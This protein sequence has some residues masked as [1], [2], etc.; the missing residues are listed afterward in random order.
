MLLWNVD[1]SEPTVVGLFLV[2][3]VQCWRCVF[4]AICMRFIYELYNTRLYKVI[5]RIQELEVSDNE[6]DVNTDKLFSKDGNQ[7][8]LYLVPTTSSM[9]AMA[10]QERQSRSG[11]NKYQ[12]RVI[13]SS[14]NVW[15]SSVCKGAGH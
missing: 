11:E 6:V 12:K 4:Y 10:V 3:T 5:H 9:D 2:V 14:T 15:Q 13:T 1:R 7:T 8:V